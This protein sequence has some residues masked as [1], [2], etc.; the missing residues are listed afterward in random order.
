VRI[1]AELEDLAG[2]RLT[3]LFDEPVRSNGQRAEAR[4][5]MMRFTIPQ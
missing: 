1:A 3:H 2:N 4:E 5:V